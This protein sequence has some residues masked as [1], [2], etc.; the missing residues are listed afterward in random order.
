MNVDTKIS[1]FCNGL[2]P[3]KKFGNT[4]QLSKPFKFCI[5]NEFN[6][7]QFEFVV[8]FVVVAGK[9]MTGQRLSDLAKKNLSSHH[10]KGYA[11]SQC[12]LKNL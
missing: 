4:H 8:V 1:S 5:D 3:K 6:L 7:L 10:V 2:E 11:N 12:L 9:N